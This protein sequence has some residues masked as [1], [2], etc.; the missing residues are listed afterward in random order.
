M[1]FLQLLMSV[2]T[3]QIHGHISVSGKALF[4]NDEVIFNLSGSLD[5]GIVHEIKRFTYQKGASGS[6][7]MSCK[8]LI[9]NS[10]GKIS[11]IRNHNGIWKL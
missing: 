8:I 10:K 11:T 7:H 9:L 1:K 5:K 3:T 6:Y 2:N 4:T